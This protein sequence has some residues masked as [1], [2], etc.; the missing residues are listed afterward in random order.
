MAPAQPEQLQQA[1]RSPKSLPPILSSRHAPVLVHSKTR[2]H[3]ALLTYAPLPALTIPKPIGHPSLESMK[4]R[5]GSSFHIQPAV[6]YD[7]D[8]Y[9]KGPFVLAGT[10]CAA[11]ASTRFK[12]SKFMVR[13]RFDRRRRT[14]KRTLALH[15]RA[16]DTLTPQPPTALPSHRLRRGLSR[17]KPRRRMRKEP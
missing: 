2:A 8:V 1:T 10:L 12:F 15:G 5:E 17:P 13:S 14:I 11:R 9:R 4:P 3:D 16:R 6:A 7:H